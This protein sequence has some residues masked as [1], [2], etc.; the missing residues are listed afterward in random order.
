MGANARRRSSLK[1]AARAEQP[2][3]LRLAGFRGGKATKTMTRLQMRAREIDT[4]QQF[5]EIIAKAHPDTRGSI[6]KLLEPWLRPGLPCCGPA[7]LATVLERQG[8]NVERW[9]HTQLCPS[10]N[11]VQLVTE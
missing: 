10:R 8:K 6:R 7:Q 2:A 3:T 5:E 9:E 11:R 4:L 1:L